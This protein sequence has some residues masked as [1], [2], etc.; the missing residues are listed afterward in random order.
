MRFKW[1][2]W[3]SCSRHWACTTRWIPAAWTAWPRSRRG[4]CECGK[5]PQ[6]R[7]ATLGKIELPSTNGRSGGPSS[8]Y[9]ASCGWDATWLGSHLSA[10]GQCYSY[11]FSCSSR[12]E[13]LDMPDM[14]MG[15][16]VPILYIFWTTYVHSRHF[17]DDIYIYIW[18][19]D[20]LILWW[21][22]DVPV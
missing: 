15:I 14:I 1:L 6:Q 17:Y 4:G 3:W 21:M 20:A 9:A 13:A 11:I 5:D 16:W 2:I 7:P 22:I 10:R 18:L 19:F 8:R 12:A